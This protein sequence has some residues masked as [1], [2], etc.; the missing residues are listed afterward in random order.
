MERNIICM[1]N[2]CKVW[3]WFTV[4]PVF[5]WLSFGKLKQLS[6]HLMYPLDKNHI[7]L[8]SV[9]GDICG[10][11]YRPLCY[12]ANCL[13]QLEVITVS[14]RK[15]NPKRSQSQPCLSLLCWWIKKFFTSKRGMAVAKN[16]MQI[17]ESNSDS[18]QKYSNT[19]IVLRA[20]EGKLVSCECS[21]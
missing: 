2:I 11:V 9:G 4:S 13:L 5:H 18:S 15:K 14:I 3:A 17:Y 1:T 8:A 7:T 20:C 6:S 21:C 10:K 19:D 16:K 12:L